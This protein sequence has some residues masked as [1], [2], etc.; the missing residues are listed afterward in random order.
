MGRTPP[1]GFK[2]F[3][4]SRCACLCVI[5]PLKA[6]VAC[7][8]P[9][10]IL[11]IFLTVFFFL[12]FLFSAAAAAA[13]DATRAKL[14]RWER[15]APPSVPLLPRRQNERSCQGE[16]VKRTSSCSCTTS[17]SSAHRR[18]NTLFRW[19][20]IVT[21]ASGDKDSRRARELVRR[22]VQHAGGDF[23]RRWDKRRGREGGLGLG[24]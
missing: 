13:A 10:S 7:V 23:M 4:S 24:F 11:V 5:L 15:L 1:P 12:V 21:V 17:V 20:V 9:E 6:V 18:S 16:N 3:K 2:G 14:T 19:D 8:K 22:R